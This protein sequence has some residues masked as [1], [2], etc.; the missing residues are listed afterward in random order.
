[1]KHQD[2]FYHAFT[3][4]SK[5][6][7][8]GVTRWFKMNIGLI[9]NL[10]GGKTVTA[11][12]LSKE[13]FNK[14]IIANIGLVDSK[15]ISNDMFVEIVKKNYERPDELRKIFGNKTLLLD[16]I[17]NLI[18]AR[19]SSTTLNELLTNFFMMLGKINSHLI[20]TSQVVTSQT[21]R[22]VRDL[23]S[24]FG[25]CYRIDV[26]GKPLIFDDRKVKQKIFIAVIYEIITIKGVMNFTDV[27]DPAPYFKMYNT[28]EI[29]LLDRTQ[30]LKG[31][32]KD[33]RK[34]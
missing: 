25:E 20:Y 33:L 26:N 1:M 21:D 34:W 27:F 10:S 19:R 11:I 32:L 7:L 22:R 29:T 2:K 15:F 17:Y 14:P 4:V 6:F 30:Y 3:V 16:E 8:F 18:S 5:D 31:G 12:R 9:G 23:T 28:E 24:L 13:L